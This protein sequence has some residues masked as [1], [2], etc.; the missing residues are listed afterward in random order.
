MCAAVDLTGYL[1]NPQACAIR[2]ERAR[3]RVLRAINHLDEPRS[4]LHTNDTVYVG[5]RPSYEPCSEERDYLRLAG[6]L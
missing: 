3:V 2:V 1:P 5:T 4:C 6:P